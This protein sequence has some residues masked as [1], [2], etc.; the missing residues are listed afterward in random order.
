MRVNV[1]SG[2]STEFI[3]WKNEF[4][5]LKKKRFIKYAY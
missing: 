3:K 2:N 4:I 5:K 1:N